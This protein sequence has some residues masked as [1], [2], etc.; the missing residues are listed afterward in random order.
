MRPSPPEA[1]NVT[2]WR[3]LRFLSGNKQRPPTD[4]PAREGPSAFAHAV[5]VPRLP[6]VRFGKHE[7]F[8]EEF[9]MFANWS[10]SVHTLRQA[11]ASADSG[12]FPKD[13]PL[14]AKCAHFRLLTL[15]ERRRV[16]HDGEL[17]ATFG[18]RVVR[19]TLAGIILGRVKNNPSLL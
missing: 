17:A 16:S 15:I 5:P 14:P 9:F 13:L 4:R 8:P 18:V 10:N 12:L 3:S 1:A 2:P 11:R 6:T 7:G 19:E